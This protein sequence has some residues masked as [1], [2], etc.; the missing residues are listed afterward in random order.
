MGVG[1]KG[2]ALGR[3]LRFGPTSRG[4]LAD[5]VF[6][7]AVPAAALGG[8]GDTA[9]FPVEEGE[10]ERGVEEAAEPEPV[11]PR[12]EPNPPKTEAE[13]PGRKPVRS[14]PRP[15]RT[16]SPLPGRGGIG[17]GWR[18]RPVRVRHPRH[19]RRERGEHGSC[20][21]NGVV[22]TLPGPAGSAAPR[23]KP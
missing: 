16:P 18:R 20:A 17:P 23:C 3:T 19:L 12:Q 21:W 14:L 2:D 13:T 4:G 5:F 22:L 1:G 8:C 6:F 11:E 7:F 10:R 15:H 9:S